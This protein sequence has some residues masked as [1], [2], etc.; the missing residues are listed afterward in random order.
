MERQYRWRSINFILP[1]RRRFPLVVFATRAVI[2]RLHCIANKTALLSILCLHPSS[3]EKTS[4][5]HCINA[6]YMH[7]CQDRQNLSILVLFRGVLRNWL[8][9]GH[10]A[11]VVKEKRCRKAT[12][13][14]CLKAENRNWDWAWN[15]A[16]LLDD[17]VV[18]F[19]PCTTVVRRVYLFVRA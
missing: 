8:L 9:H 7:A 16:A 13:N 3:N 19:L 12:T 5:M 4:T 1:P 18:N 11:D 15:E 6:Q 14:D 17:R 10:K 2:T